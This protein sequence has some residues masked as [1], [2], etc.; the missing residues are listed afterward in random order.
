MLPRN[1][2]VDELLPRGGTQ[3]SCPTVTMVE[4]RGRSHLITALPPFSLLTGW[5]FRVSDQPQAPAN[6][7]CVPRTPPVGQ[8]MRD[9]FQPVRKLNDSCPTRKTMLDWAGEAACV[10]VL[11]RRRSL[12]GQSLLPRVG[13]VAQQPPTKVP[14]CKAH[15]AEW[16]CSTDL[17]D[18]AR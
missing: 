5:L 9:N 6:V 12:M 10:E 8:K 4:R 18:C 1:I 15:V 11:L 3:T 14:I 16:Y 13:T 17:P 7:V 2:N